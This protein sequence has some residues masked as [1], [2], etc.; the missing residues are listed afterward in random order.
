MAEIHHLGN[1]PAQG[2][3]EL[4]DAVER[5]E[6]PQRFLIVSGE[7]RGDLVY[8]VVRCYGMPN[9]FEAAGLLELGKLSFLSDPEVA[10]G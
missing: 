1:N 10:G 6:G 2:L 5:G 3:R 8:P 7:V 9:I 4:A